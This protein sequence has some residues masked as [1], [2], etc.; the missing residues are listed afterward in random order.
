MLRFKVP[1]KIE[2]N[3]F[4]VAILT[5]S[6]KKKRKSTI[7][8]CKPVNHLQPSKGQAIRK[9]H[10]SKHY[11]K[12]CQPTNQ[13][14]HPNNHACTSGVTMALKGL[15]VQGFYTSQKPCIRN[16]SPLL[17]ETVANQQGSPL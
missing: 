4:S 3:D 15:P 6:H 13:Q 14:I 17:R 16:W 1:I 9:T 7:R 11:S 8:L 2:K 5:R 12:K 10:P